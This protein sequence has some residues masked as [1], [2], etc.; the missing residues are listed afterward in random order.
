MKALLSIP[1]VRDI[2]TMQ[3]GRMVLIGCGFLSSILYARMLGLGGYGEYA[4][5][6]AFTGTFGLFTNLGQQATTLTFFAEAYGRKD[7]KAL[8]EIL[9]YYLV[10]S[11]CAAVLLGLFA[12]LAPILTG[13]IYD[14]RHIGELAG[15]VFVSSICELGF[16]YYSIVLQTVRNIRL[17]TLLENAKTVLQ[18]GI[19]VWFLL[20]GYGVAGVLWS[21]LITAAIFSAASCILYPSLRAEHDLPRI[22]EALFAGTGRSLWKYTKD[23]LWIAADK[24]IGNL[25]PNIFL[26]ALSTQVQESVVGSLRLAFKLG[27]LPSSFGLASVGRLASS[28]IPSVAGRGHDVLVKKLRQLAA[29][30]VA[31][32]GIITLCGLL[33][34]PALLPVVYGE[35]FGIAMYP[36]VVIAILNLTLSIHI[37]VTPILRVY[38]KIQIAAVLSA[39]GTVI[40]MAIFFPLSNALRP[41]WALYISLLAYHVIIGLVVFPVLRLIRTAPKQR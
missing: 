41:T 18:L 26:F 3:I 19:A 24:S 16:I 30:T 21:W 10:L 38:S 13:W 33:I 11:L 15:I 37:L 17:L 14:D 8:A 6:L 34:V 23:G 2:A 39:I 22:G 7:T 5:V 35:H 12:L 29:H 31:M 32:H 9:Q 28:V 36:F 40:A 1:F 20:Q 27:G 25:Y 4:V